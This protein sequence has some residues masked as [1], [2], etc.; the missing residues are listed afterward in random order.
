MLKE[1]S[2]SWKCSS[3]KGY[4]DK[5]WVVILFLHFILSDQ[6]SRATTAE[7]WNKMLAEVYKP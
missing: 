3:L 6:H 7:A 2:E 5:S 4:S 1:N